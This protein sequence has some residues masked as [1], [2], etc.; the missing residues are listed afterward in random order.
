MYKNFYFVKISTP[1]FR[2]LAYLFREILR[3][4]KN[5]PFAKH[6]NRAVFLP[7]FHGSQI[8][9]RG[10]IWGN[11]KLETVDPAEIITSNV[12]VT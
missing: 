7:L 12:D 9:C 8:G 1:K 2:Y 3:K 6:A 10:G 11:I 4:T 5:G